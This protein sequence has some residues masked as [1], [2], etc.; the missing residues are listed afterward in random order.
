MKSHKKS[1]DIYKNSRK[2][3]ILST[4]V[5][6]CLAFIFILAFIVSKQNDFRDSEIFTSLAKK[7][8][9]L[10]PDKLSKKLNSLNMLNVTPNEKQLT[11]WLRILGP[12]KTLEEIFIDSDSGYSADCHRAA[13]LIGRLSYELFGPSAFKDGNSSCHSG[14]YH[15]AMESFLRA[16]G[17]NNL[18]QKISDICNNFK[19]RF[20]HYECLHGV[21]HGV[22]AYTNYQLPEAID[23]CRGLRDTFEKNSCFGGVFMENLVIA[24]ES[25]GSTGHKTDW[26]KYDDY[27]FPCSLY[28]DDP[29]VSLRCYLNQTSWMFAI[30]RSDLDKVSQECLK[31]PEGMK[32][33]CFISLGRDIAGN[34]LRVPEK[35]KEG[36]DKV[37]KQNDYYQS[38]IIGGLGV[39][40]DFFGPDIKNQATELC[41]IVPQD[42]KDG[43]YSKLYMR[44]QGIIENP[45]EI[46]KI[47]S[48]FEKEYQ[49]NCQL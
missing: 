16:E 10:F 39:I 7:Y 44:L 11:Y 24:R 9:S 1:S 36:C 26:V 3:K 42:T 43:C 4:L 34:S 27:H 38:C 22:L 15:G 46:K 23:V 14:F 48:G 6:I 25:R 8:Y 32:N 19:T 18:G 37:P 5:L 31:A 40:L 47:C 12:K 45:N 17:T 13:H 35:I 20:T 33:P 41:L 49:K 21:G 29:D 28:L 2:I 30:S